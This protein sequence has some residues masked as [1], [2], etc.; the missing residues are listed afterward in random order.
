[1]NARVPIILILGGTA[2][3][4]DIAARL[5]ARGIAVTTSLAGRTREPK[6]VHGKVRT[7]GFGG[8]EGLAAFI[9]ENHISLLVDLTHPFAHRMSR[10]ARK[11]SQI[12]AIPL[13]HWQRPGWT[14]MEGDTWVEVPDIASAIIAIPAHARV[15]LALGSQHIAP[16]ATR[17]DVHFLVRMVDAPDAPLPLPDHELLLSRPGSVEEEFALLRDKQITRIVCRNSGGKASYAKIAAARLLGLPVIVIGRVADQSAPA[18]SLEEFEAQIL[19]AA[20]QA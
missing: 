1:M 17:A 2:E 20:S 11:A 6:P 18:N 13:L 5:H 4:A 16:F 9:Q 12:A 8:A 10:N 19:A 15:L 14:R 3:A 7:G